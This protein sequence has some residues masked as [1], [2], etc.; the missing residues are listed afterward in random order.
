MSG[1]AGVR[2]AGLSF[3]PAPSLLKSRDQPPFAV[4]LLPLDDKS[5]D[6]EVDGKA[7][8]ISCLTQYSQVR[9]AENWCYPRFYPSLITK[10]SKYFVVYAKQRIYTQ[11]VLN[12]T[13]QLRRLLY[14]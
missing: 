5:Q 10:P 14:L 12:A 3:L 9:D 8:A 11:Y 6:R 4:L 13:S 2:R 1:R 7:V